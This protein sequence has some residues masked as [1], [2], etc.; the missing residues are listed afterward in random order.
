M[1]EK[2]EEKIYDKNQKQLK[3]GDLVEWRQSDKYGQGLYG[4]G[5]IQTL[6]ILQITIKLDK[7]ITQYFRGFG[8]QSDIVT[9]L[10][11]GLY[12]TG[13]FSF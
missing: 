4:V 9:I 1:S 6:S 3:V 5:I 10:G 7:P 2:V 12:M 13:E 11:I 8:R